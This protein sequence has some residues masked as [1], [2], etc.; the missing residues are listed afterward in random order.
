M[1]RPHEKSTKIDY[2]AREGGGGGYVDTS[3]SRLHTFQGFSS[4][5]QRQVAR[6]L[7]A[8]IARTKTASL[9]W[10]V[11]E[12]VG[13]HETGVHTGTQSTLRWRFVPGVVYGIGW[14]A[15]VCLILFPYFGRFHLIVSLC[16]LLLSGYSTL[17]LGSVLGG[18]QAAGVAG[19][20]GGQVKQTQ[21]RPAAQGVRADA[22][23]APRSGDVV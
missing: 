19:G 16:V 14:A 2:S 4:L 11:T 23:G 7:L 10:W 20:E 21:G 15:V 5:A 6:Q 12:G 22:G 18:G 1:R 13:V 3:R 17:L 9:T 8:Y